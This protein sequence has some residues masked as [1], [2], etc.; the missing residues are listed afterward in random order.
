M[1]R[2]AS[3]P[4]LA[5][6]VAAAGLGCAG[7]VAALSPSTAV[8]V[9]VAAALLVVVHLGRSA[10]LTAL[11]IIAIFISGLIASRGLASS[12]K[13]SEVV[14]LIVI[15]A[16]GLGLTEHLSRP[17]WRRTLDIQTCLLVAFLAVV[18]VHV[19][20]GALEGQTHRA[21][22]GARS[23]CFLPMLF[24]VCRG[25]AQAQRRLSMLVLGVAI[26]VAGVLI[27]GYKQFVYGYTPS[28]L[29]L[30]N[31]ET[32]ST[33][34]LGV[35]RLSATLPTNQ[36]F[37]AMLIV[38][39]PA[40][41]A[42]AIGS[43][44]TRRAKMFTTCLAAAAAGLAVL[45]MVRSAAIAAAVGSLVVALLV[46]RDRAR[47]VVSFVLVLVVAA[48]AVQLLVMN[49]GRQGSAVRSRLGTLTELASD[50]ALNARVHGVWPKVIKAIAARPLG[51]GVATTG[52]PAIKLEGVQ[53]AV[54]PDNGY[55]TIAYE[56]GIVG[57]VV[58]VAFICTAA[59]GAV[60]ALR[61]SLNPLQRS[62]CLAAL[63][64]ALSVLVAMI[65]ASYVQLPTLQI[66]LFPLL[67]AASGVAS[68][69]VNS[70]GVNG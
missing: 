36:D 16:I 8:G 54:I 46:S 70:L 28:E 25:I 52:G 32:H 40:A 17:G 9:I 66:L 31:V 22:L 49:T 2:S 34:Y 35:P 63:G 30:A 59:L 19:G 58:Y 47:R 21:L 55:L 43:S 3:I 6:V 18:L 14:A 38:I 45:G 23:W 26:G 12:G 51:H 64:A 15:A 56:L 13:W 10:A 48:F 24:F 37:A 29:A 69:R 65:G 7:V 27:Y 39:L 57:V 60:R 61:T 42:F 33:F 5:T 50:P 20:L 44:S 41:V 68:L 53:M 11:A 1:R 4:G 62:V 67:G